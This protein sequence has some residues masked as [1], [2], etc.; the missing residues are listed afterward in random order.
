MCVDYRRLNNMSVPDQYYMPTIDDILE[1]V[2]I[3]SSF[4]A[5]PQQGV[6]SGFYS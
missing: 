5:R 2:E 6:L 4:K 3:H 1:K